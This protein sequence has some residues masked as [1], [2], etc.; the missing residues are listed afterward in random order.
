MMIDLETEVIIDK[1]LTVIEE[2]SLSKAY[3]DP[4]PYLIGDKVNRL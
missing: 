1:E 4:N 3:S 2:L